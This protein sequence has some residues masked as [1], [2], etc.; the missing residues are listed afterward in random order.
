MKVLRLKV[1]EKARVEARAELSAAFAEIKAADNA[2]LA[3][4]GLLPDALRMQIAKAR[5]SL[6]KI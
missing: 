2:I 6:S 4:A 5:N 3:V 1:R